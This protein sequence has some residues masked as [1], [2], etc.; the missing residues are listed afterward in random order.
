MDTEKKG[1]SITVFLSVLVIFVLF[2]ELWAEWIDERE[3]KKESGITHTIAANGDGNNLKIKLEFI[4][5]LRKRN[6]LEE[7]YK[8]ILALHLSTKERIEF[9]PFIY[10]QIFKKVKGSPM[11]VK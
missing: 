8:E 10:K 6:A 9:Y 7:D 3:N 5:Q 4:R 2:G 1:V 11:R